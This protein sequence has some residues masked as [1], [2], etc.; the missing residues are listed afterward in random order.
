MKLQARYKELRK[1]FYAALSAPI[2]PNTNSVIP[3]EKYEYTVLYRIALD[4]LRTVRGKDSQRII[5]LLNA[6]NSQPHLLKH[7]KTGKKSDQIQALSLLA[8]FDDEESLNTL[9]RYAESDD[10]YV[11]LAAMRSLSMRRDIKDTNT[12]I[13]KLSTTQTTN[14]LLLADVLSRFGQT[15]T[16]SLIQLVRK[17]SAKDV[18]LAAIMALGNM[19]AFNAVEALSK[20]LQG[21]DVDIKMHSAIALG[22]IGNTDAGKILTEALHDKNHAVRMHAAE[23]L[24]MLQM[25]DALPA[26]TNSLSDESWWVR[27]RAAEALNNLG[28]RGIAAL[29]S[30]SVGNDAA[31]LIATQVLAE[32]GSA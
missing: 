21:S 9:M 16:S 15:A 27:F 2:E 28:A 11:Q 18:K 14:S 8:F 30:V 6:W 12:L 31:A 13:E 19:R 32:K 24:G 17:Q 22:K 23:A 5:A 26:L 29:K 7:I 10:T 3:V 1:Y 25:D 4:L 20:S